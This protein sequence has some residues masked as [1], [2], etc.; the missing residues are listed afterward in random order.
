MSTDKKHNLIFLAQYAVILPVLI[1]LSGASQYTPEVKAFLCQLA[2]IADIEKDNAYFIALKSRAAWGVAVLGMDDHS[3]KALLTVHREQC[4]LIKEF[5]DFVEKAR[6]QVYMDDSDAP[7]CKAL[8]KADNI[9]QSIKFLVDQ[10]ISD[11][12]GTVDEVRKAIDGFWKKGT[13]GFAST[14]TGI[15]LFVSHG[16]VDKPLATAISREVEAAGIATWRDD[17]DIV[18]GDSIPDEIARGLRSATHLIVILSQNSIGRPWIKTEL[19]NAIMLFHSDGTPKI[20]PIL[21]D[22]I[23]PPPPIAHLKGIQ[24]DDFDSG[25][26]SL[27]ASLGVAQTDRFDLT[28]VYIFYRKSKKAIETLQW[29]NQADFFLP[30]NEESFD[31]L[32]DM[33]LFFE[34]VGIPDEINT[35]RRYIRT[36]LGNMGGITAPGIDEDFY[37]YANSAYAGIS[38][39]RKIAYFGKKILRNLNP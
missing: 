22:G 32:E 19:D 17:K 13:E 15:K 30:I 23:K 1:R 18:G 38:L 14:S 10:S 7:L 36:L 34:S 6:P 31:Q 37:S 16:T 12:L 33:E 24:F 2:T 8:R 25:M 4:R 11:A 27:F 35:P 39:A 9:C 3:T 5:N 29:C 26:I 20:I 21:L 28:T